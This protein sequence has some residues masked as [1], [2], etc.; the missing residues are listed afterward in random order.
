[1]K[2]ILLLLCLLASFSVFAQEVEVTFQLDMSGQT[3][4]A[5]GIHVA[6][7]LNGWST[8]SI[9]LT[10]MGDDIYAAT[11]SLQSGRDIQY[12]FL[13]GNAWG[14]EEV[15]PLTCAVN[16][17][18]RI[19]TTPLEDVTLATV[20]FGGCPAT[21]ETKMVTFRVD[22]SGQ[23]VDA[24]GVHLAGNFQGW[25]PG[26]TRMTDMGNGIFETTV[27]VLNS[28]IVLQYKFI[29]GNEWGMDEDPPEGCE[30]FDNNRA[31]VATGVEDIVLPTQT[32]AGCD[33]PIPTKDVTFRVDMTGFDVSPDGVHLAGNLQGWNPAGT[34]M[35]DAGNGVY[36]VTVP[37]PAAAASINY[38]FVNG[39]A[40]GMEEDPPEGCQNNDNNRFAALALTT[41]AITLPG[42]QYG[43]CEGITSLREL[44]RGDEFQLIPT[45]SNDRVLVKWQLPQAE[46]VS[47][48]VLDMNGRTITEEK[49]AAT[50]LLMN[51]SLEVGGWAP[52]MYLVYLQTDSGHSVRKLVVR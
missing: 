19:F 8:D 5:D 27:A 22:M 9:E 35:T 49:I 36:E 2:P 16:G 30:N 31:A 26:S 18:N 33:N 44:L 23:T 42:V 11:V 21:V 39:N 20:P 15:P 32:F 4:S 12:K 50:N 14:T 1:M 24:N 28:V 25:S 48:R 46:L 41:D 38:K 40:W 47:M 52:G 3:V 7:D 6:G 17:N 43:S 10:A 29:N 51:R 13:N 37:V 45:V 34:P